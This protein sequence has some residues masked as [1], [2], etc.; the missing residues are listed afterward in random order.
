MKKKNYESYFEKY[1]K[2]KKVDISKNQSF[3]LKDKNKLMNV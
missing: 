2:I 1:I 3:Y